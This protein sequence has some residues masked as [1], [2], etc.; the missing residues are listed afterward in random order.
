MVLTLNNG[1][2][3]LWTVIKSNPNPTPL[4]LPN[5]RMDEL[6]LVMNT[7]YINHP[8]L[9][10]FTS[11]CNQVISHRQSPVAPLLDNPQGEY[12]PP[13][14][15]HPHHLRTLP[16]PVSILRAHPFP[17]QSFHSQYTFLISPFLYSHPPPPANRRNSPFPAHLRNPPN[18][19]FH[20]HLH[21]LPNSLPNSLLFNQLLLRV[22][23]LP[24]TTP[25]NWRWVWVN[26]CQGSIDCNSIALRLLTVPPLHQQW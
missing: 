3:N 4:Y 15:C 25:R 6:T 18:N 9:F 26:G 5:C 11:R 8:N 23:N 7:I 20:A 19:L 12:P 21:N 22:V 16:I 17:S 2:P 13:L 10:L 1:N 14:L 24:R